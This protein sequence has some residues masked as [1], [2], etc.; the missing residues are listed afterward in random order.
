MHKYIHKK[1]PTSFSDMFKDFRGFRKAPLKKTQF[2]L[3]CLE[4]LE[5]LERPRM[6][7]ANMPTDARQNL[8]GG[9]RAITTNPN[10]QSESELPN[11]FTQKRN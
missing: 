6:L 3:S 10:Q 2:F 5:V 8:F 9:F 4:D 7:K 1:L 11:S